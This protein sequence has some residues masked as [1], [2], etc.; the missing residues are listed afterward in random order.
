[1]HE[2][3]IA[4]ALVENVEAEA[5]KQ[6]A[7]VVSEV[8]VDI[9]EL[10]FVGETQLKFAYDVIT[11]EIE[12]LAKSK[13]VI[14]TVKAEVSCES[15]GYTGGLKNYDDPATHFITP[16]FACPSCGGKITIIKGREC[17]IRTI[18]MMVED[19]V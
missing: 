9:G 19:D 4:K 2:F 10:S 7:S 5:A 18:R 15:C 12:A 6:N 1:M 17:T 11:R 16:V 13:L 14:Q 8:V 3:G